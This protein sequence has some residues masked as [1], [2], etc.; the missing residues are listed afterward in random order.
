M[1]NVLILLMTLAWLSAPAVHVTASEKSEVSFGG[2][3]S[4]E[5]WVMDEDEAML[6]LDG[7][8][9]DGPWDDGRYE[10]TDTMWTLDSCGSRFNATFKREHFRGFV[11]IRPHN[12]VSVRHWYAEWD[13]GPGFLLIGQTFRPVYNSISSSKAQCTAN[14]SMTYGGDTRPD[15][16]RYPMIRL[17]FPFSAGQFQMAFLDPSRADIDDEFGGAE[18]DSDTTLPMI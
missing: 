5:T 18:D 4:F 10:D 7:A 9:N 13:F 3:V 12:G 17:R 16:T 8:P 1:K 6:D 2:F 14:F 15:C 11:E